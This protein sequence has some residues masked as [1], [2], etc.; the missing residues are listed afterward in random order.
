MQ[1]QGAEFDRAKIKCIRQCSRE[2]EPI[3]C[4]CKYVYVYIYIQI[5]AI[6]IISRSIH[7]YLCL[8][9]YLYLYIQRERVYKELAH[10]IMEVGQLQDLQGNQQDVDPGLLLIQFEAESKGLRTRRANDVV[11]VQRSAGLRSQKSQCFSLS[12]KARKKSE[13]TSRR[14]PFYSSFLFQSGLQLI[15]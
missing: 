9:L 7:L 13:T 3:R 10:R 2:T 15:R 8:Y 1:W 12:P 4:R 6:Q 11:A 5:I 14:N